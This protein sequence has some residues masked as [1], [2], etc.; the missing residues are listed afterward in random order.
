MPP[1]SFRGVPV[2]NKKPRDFSDGELIRASGLT[3]Q[4]MHADSIKGYL[5]P[6]ELVLPVRYT[7]QKG[8]KKGKTVPLAKMGEKWLRHLGVQLP[9]MK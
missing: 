4:Q 3:K 5:M 8:P 6:N 2:Y 7:Y 1:Y 9:G